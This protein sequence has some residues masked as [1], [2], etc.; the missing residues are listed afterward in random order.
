MPYYAVCVSGVWSSWTP[1]TRAL[2]QARMHS[3]QE[4]FILKLFT[5]K[6]G[7]SLGLPQRQLRSGPVPQLQGWEGSV[8][9]PAAQEDRRRGSCS[10]ICGAAVS[11]WRFLG[12]PGAVRTRGKEVLRTKTHEWQAL[13]SASIY[14]DNNELTQRG[15]LTQLKKQKSQVTWSNPNTHAIKKP[16]MIKW[17]TIQPNWCGLEIVKKWGEAKLRN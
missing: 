9:G 13:H 14:R 12:N 15:V 11:L 6:G 2:T 4:A 1:I 5:M 17:W 7:G 16:Q 8:T 3:T 10:W